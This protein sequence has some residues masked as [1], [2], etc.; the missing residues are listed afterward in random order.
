[1]AAKLNSAQLSQAFQ[2]MTRGDI[3]PMIDPSIAYG[4]SYNQKEDADAKN[5]K[6]FIFGYHRWGDKTKVISR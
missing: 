6:C 1:M 4:A 3:S 5:E 2:S